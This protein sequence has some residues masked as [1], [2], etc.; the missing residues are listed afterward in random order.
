MLN[1]AVRSKNGQK[2]RFPAIEM[3]STHH[4]EIHDGR[5]YLPGYGPDNKNDFSIEILGPVVEEVEGRRA[6]RSFNSKPA[7]KTTRL[8]PGKT[9]NGHS[10]LLK[11]K[12]KNFSVLLGGDLN[13]SAEMFLLGHYTGL[14][15]Y[16]QNDVRN[17]EI[18]EAAK[19][20]FKVDLAKSCHHGSADF[21][22]LFLESLNTTATVIS[23]G[24]GEKHALPRSDT[25]GAIGYHGR[26]ARPLIFSTE[27]AR[28]TE[29][30][31]KRDESLWY[32]GAQL[33]GKAEATTDKTRK[34]NLNEQAYELLETAKKRN[35]TVYGSINMRSDGEK[36]VLAYMLESPS[37]NRRWDVYTLESIAGGNLQYRKAKDASYD[38]AKRRKTHSPIFK[39]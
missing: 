17:D 39:H 4:G 18:I 32:K 25:M 7:E 28:S 33:K 8:N 5:S 38:E 31:S 10:I 24:D 14:P 13:T 15:V 2:R 6:L 19:P 37:K 21:S 36:V 35:V 26:G 23:S 27:L 29:E 3:L 9:K 34:K 1:D 16:D 12:Y 20:T 11:L 22:D 30:F